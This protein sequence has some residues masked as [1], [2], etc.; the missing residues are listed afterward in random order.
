MIY[1]LVLFLCI[2]QTTLT[3]EVTFVNSSPDG[4]YQSVVLSS[5]YQE[6]LQEYGNS[7]ISVG[8]YCDFTMGDRGRPWTIFANLSLSNSSYTS[9]IRAEV[10][11]DNKQ[12]VFVTK[13]TATG[14]GNVT[15]LGSINTSNS[16]DC[17]SYSKISAQI[18]TNN[19][20]VDLRK[21]DL[22][23]GSF[24]QNDLFSVFD[25]LPTFLKGL[26]EQE[27]RMFPAQKLKTFETP[28]RLVEYNEETKVRV[29]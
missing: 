19:I 9:P 5:Y 16:T 29:D 20:E 28:Y 4:D 14:P 18:I 3:Q 26:K 25:A 7:C 11:D 10:W 17:I 21:K 1:T 2:L 24:K 22:R 15:D 13:W 6:T 8:G 23:L 12:C 27:A